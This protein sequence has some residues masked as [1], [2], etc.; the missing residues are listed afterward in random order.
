MTQQPPT[1]A[2]WVD[3][4]TTGA[5]ENAGEVLEVG[6]V[7][8]PLTPLAPELSRYSLVIR[9]AEQA[10]PLMM[11]EVV[12]GMHVDSGL[13]DE[14]HDGREPLTRVL[15]DKLL[16][17]WRRAAARE[18]GASGPFV[19]AGSGVA[20]F[21]ARWL[22]L[23]FPEFSRALTYYTL[24]VGVMRRALDWADAGMPPYPLPETKAHRALDDAL[25]HLAEW[26]W[27]ASHLQNPCAWAGC[28]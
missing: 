26:R 2:M 14:I 1:H 6:C 20:H 25:D 16:V 24:D 18:V 22:R 23:H 21:D 4:E 19:L 8:T 10:W 11:N 5:D 3:L 7:L 17:A 12:H 13:L 15:V 27:Y 28:S 9:P